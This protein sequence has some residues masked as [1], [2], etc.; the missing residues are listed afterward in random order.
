M[1]G[2]HLPPVAEAVASYLMDGDYTCPALK[3]GRCSVY[4]VRPTLCRLW[5]VVEDMPCPWGCVP[6]GGRLPSIIGQALLDS[7]FNA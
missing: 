5:G 2:I 1:K 4:D 3:D 7:T 6:D